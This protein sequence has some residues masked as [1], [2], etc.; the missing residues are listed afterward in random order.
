MFFP[1]TSIH[2]ERITNAYIIGYTHLQIIPKKI[3]LQSEEKKFEPTKF[4]KLTG[5]LLN[6][7]SQLQTV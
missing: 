4:R 5:E 1:S 3:K 2:R 6:K 7:Y